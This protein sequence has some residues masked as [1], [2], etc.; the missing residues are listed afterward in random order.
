L[1]R[2]LDDVDRLERPVVRATLD[3]RGVA[4]LDRLVAANESADAPGT[5]ANTL[6]LQLTPKNGRWVLVSDAWFFKEGD[7]ERWQ[8]ARYG[9]FRVMPDGRALLVGMADAQLKPITSPRQ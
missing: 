1:R 6:R 7:G 2:Q 5:T 8:A 3:E 9:E 4:G